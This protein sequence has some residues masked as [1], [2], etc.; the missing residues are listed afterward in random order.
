MMGWIMIDYE[1]M[2]KRIF[3]LLLTALVSASLI[4]CA[5]DGAISPASDTGGSPL[6][7]ESS[8]V[9]V[10][11][12]TA[13]AEIPAFPLPPP[14]L[15]PAWDSDEW[16]NREFCPINDGPFGDGG[17]LAMI[18]V[19][20]LIDGDF[21]M[22]TSWWFNQWRS[23]T[24]ELAAYLSRDRLA[25]IRDEIFAAVGEFEQHG[26]DSTS[27]LSPFDE[28]VRIAYATTYHAGGI[29]VFT[30]YR[31]DSRF[32]GFSFEFYTADSSGNTGGRFH[33]EYIYNTDTGE[34]S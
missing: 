16:E 3:A 26:H 7:S 9:S 20:S 12:E 30:L 21:D 10:V 17:V 31:E 4:G 22:R 19:R 6:P 5:G 18:F 23:L 24:E 8:A 11:S 15:T 27:L 32:A 29:T 25:E 13:S 28:G 2:K 1:N 14:A 34:I 33:G